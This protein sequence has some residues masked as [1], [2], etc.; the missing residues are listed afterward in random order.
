MINL[1][2]GENVVVLTLSENLTN[3]GYGFIFEIDGENKLYFTT[4]NISQYTERYDKFTFYV[5]SGST[6]LLNGWFNLNSGLYDYTVYEKLYPI[7]LSDLS[8]NSVRNLNVLEYGK[9][10]KEGTSIT[11][12]YYKNQGVTKKY[13]K[14]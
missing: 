7:T 6:D 10:R 9:L 1:K 14:K 5:N 11:K 8:E 4:M 13:Y 2:D 12:E 3:S